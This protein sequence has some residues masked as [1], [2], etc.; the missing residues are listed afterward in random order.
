MILESRPPSALDVNMRIE[1]KNCISAY[2]SDWRTALSVMA[3]SMGKRSSE[4]GI[5]QPLQSLAR[6]QYSLCLML[7]LFDERLTRFEA[8]LSD[9]R[10]EF[11]AY[12]EAM[13]FLDA[14]YLL[15][16][17]LLDSTAGIVRHLYKHNEKC[18]LPKSF[19]KMF[20]MSAK[21]NLPDNLNAVFLGCETWFP[22]LKDR[23]DDIVHHYETYFIAFEHDSVGQTTPIQ[24]SPRNKTNAFRDEDLRSFIGDV[25]AGYQRFLDALLD[26]LDTMFP[27]W[28]SFGRSINSRTSTIFEG[29]SANILWWAYRHG[30]Y[31]HPNLVVYES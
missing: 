26:H 25:M 17:V 1:H 6:H 18:E 29:R 12:P 10:P 9:E 19:D 11:G 21:E 27:R 24:F 31:R 22:H 13:A 8:T 23:R 3:L 28:Y 4:F 2:F 5:P 15:S 7:G 20:K 16:R 14:I 30:G